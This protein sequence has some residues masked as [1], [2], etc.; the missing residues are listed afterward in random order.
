MAVYLATMDL[1]GSFS[2]FLLE[3]RLVHVHPMTT[4]SRQLL[5]LQ[6]YRG[7]IYVKRQN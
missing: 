2:V 1:V 3:K 7:N 5:F 6:I 4:C